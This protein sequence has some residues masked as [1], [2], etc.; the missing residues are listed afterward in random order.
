MFNFFAPALY[1]V[2]FLVLELV[3]FVLLRLSLNDPVYSVLWNK[4]LRLWSLLVLLPLRL[5][6]PMSHVQTNRVLEVWRSG[7]ICVRYA[8]FFNVVICVLG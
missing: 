2:F 4:L 7:E 5:L 1:V 6:S 3:S 8:A